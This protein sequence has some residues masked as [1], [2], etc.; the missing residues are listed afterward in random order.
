MIYNYIATALIAALVAASGA[1]QIQGWRFDS[2]EKERIEAEAEKHR[3]DEKAAS[4]AATGFEKDKEKNEIRNRTITVEVDKI[5]ERLVYRNACFEPDGLRVLN[6]TIRRTDDAGQ[7]GL[8]LPR[9][10]AAR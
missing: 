8:K 3:F 7:P 2:R 4:A 1:W 9:S 10:A 5:I 6:A